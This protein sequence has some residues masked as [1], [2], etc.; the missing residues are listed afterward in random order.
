MT[1]GVL[2]G[3][4]AVVTG[5]GRGIGRAIVQR[6]A[7]QGATVVINYVANEVTA[8]ETVRL[9]VDA[10]GHARAVRFDVGDGAAVRAAFDDIVDHEGRVDILVNNAGLAI[11]QLLLRLKDDD[12]NRVLQ[13]NLTGAFH[14]ARAAVRTM[15]RARYGRIVNLTSVV[16]AMGNA[17]QVAYAAA[18][19]G[20]VG[21]TRALAREV[22]SRGI[23]VN[24]LARDSSTPGW[25]RGCRTRS[26]RHIPRSCPSGALE[27]WTTSPRRRRSC[28]RRRR[29][30]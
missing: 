30:T 6:L 13:T 19:A 26:A 16:A 21:F 28:A 12:W 18:K 9:V 5:G 29:G 27:P 4:A 15:I 1:A 10:G 22:A 3:Q 11:D 23:T 25:Q 8:E 14:C 20:V 7:A 2:A 17:G 24:A